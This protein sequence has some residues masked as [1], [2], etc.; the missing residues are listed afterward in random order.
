M[1]FEKPFA[2]LHDLCYITSMA[3][4]P[5]GRIV[6]EVDPSLKRD[7]YSRLASEGL[8][9]KQWFIR[10]A[11]DYMEERDQ[12]SLPGIS[13]LHRPQEVMF[14]AEPRGVYSTSKEPK[15]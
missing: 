5:S 7:L 6:L 10:A 15:Q 9:L 8:S 3:Q 12:P 11:A 1:S 4:G 14:A 13:P 2:M